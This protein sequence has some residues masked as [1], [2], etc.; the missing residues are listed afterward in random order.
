MEK[1]DLCAAIGI[2]KPA[3]CDA[4]TKMGPWAFLCKAHLIR[5]GVKPTIRKETNQ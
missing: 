4:K 5:V 2:D 1:C 3:I